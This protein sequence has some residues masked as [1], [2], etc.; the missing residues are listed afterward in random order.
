M[1][2]LR[3]ARLFMDA[4]VRPDIERMI[5]SNEVGVRGAVNDEPANGDRFLVFMALENGYLWLA[6]IVST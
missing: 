3:H 4:E 6:W 5:D 1:Y 2:L